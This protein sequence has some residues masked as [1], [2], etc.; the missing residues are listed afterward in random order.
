MTYLAM[1]IGTTF[2]IGMYYGH[3]SNCIGNNTT[4]LSTATHLDDYGYDVS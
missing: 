3:T 1:D 4:Y 2:H